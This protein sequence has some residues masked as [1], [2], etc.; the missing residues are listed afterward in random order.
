MKTLIRDKKTGEYY[1]VACSKNEN[2]YLSS[3]FDEETPGENDF[4]YW[5]DDVCEAYDF[6]S[7]IFAKSEMGM[8]DLTQDG[9][10]EPEIIIL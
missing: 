1:A 2:G 4:P 10:R 7:E 6:T 3:P 8:N 5:T 9:T